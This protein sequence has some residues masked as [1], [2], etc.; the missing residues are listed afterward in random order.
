[1]IRNNFSKTDPSY[2]GESLIFGYFSFRAHFHSI[3]KEA[4]LT[5]NSCVTVDISVSQHEGTS[6]KSTTEILEPGVK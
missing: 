4:H 5:E 3:D 6:S 1:M 2:M